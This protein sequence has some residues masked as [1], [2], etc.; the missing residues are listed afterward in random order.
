MFLTGVLQSFAVVCTSSIFFVYIRF[1]FVQYHIDAVV[2]TVMSMIA[3][4]FTLSILSGPGRYV[5]NTLFSWETWFYGFLVIGTY[6]LDIILVNHISGTEAGLLNRLT[7]PFT[8]IVA[9]IL[10]KRKPSA[11]HMLGNGII[12][13][14]F[15]IL[16]YHQDVALWSN[17][18]IPVTL[19]VICNAGS[20]IVAETHKEYSKALQ[21]GSLRDR[22]RVVAFVSF[23]TA[24]IFLAFCF[25]M[26]FAKNIYPVLEQSSILSFI[27]NKESYVHKESIITGLLYGFFIAPAARYFIWS[28]SQNIK[29][30]NVLAILAFI[31]VATLC[32]ESILAYFSNS[33]FHPH[34]AIVMSALFISCGA[35]LPVVLQ[36]KKEAGANSLPLWKS[37]QKAVQVNGGNLSIQHSNT[38]VD[39]YEITC[40]AL[41]YTAEDYDK[42]SELLNVS[43]DTLRVLYNGKGTLALTEDASKEF[44]R[45]Y[46]KHIAN[47]D[48][49]TGLYNRA[50]FMAEMKKIL[51][52]EGT[53][54]VFYIDLDKFKPVNDTYGHEAGDYVLK[55]ISARFTKALPKTA[56]IARLGGDEFCAV[57]AN[58]NK[59]EASNISTSLQ[60]VANEPFMFAQQEITIGASVGIS[61]YPEQG[62]TPEDLLSHADSGMY[63]EKESR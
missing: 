27:P 34:L 10:F 58:V 47:R 7:I 1:C 59:E 30:E 6:I 63:K 61:Y 45:R 23:V 40:A 12:I 35:A 57:I 24:L 48:A 9:L 42:A 22:M 15:I 53:A 8:L 25:S 36:L 51:E 17:I 62:T 26:T 2:F 60:K 55:E 50:G 31:P 29:S 37:L 16:A 3:T 41:E 38:A 14:G 43:E 44:A 54:S 4:A 18:W 39:D 52:K 33:T 21:I 13:I 32:M 11:G 46:R 56:L 28:A 19:V 49:L 5:R 20:F